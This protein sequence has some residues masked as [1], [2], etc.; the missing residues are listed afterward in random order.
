MLILTLTPPNKMFYYIP[1]VKEL[2]LTFRDCRQTA[3]AAV[4]DIGNFGGQAFD[5]LRVNSL[6]IREP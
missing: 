4:S 3:Y 2:H 1:I 6:A 5:K